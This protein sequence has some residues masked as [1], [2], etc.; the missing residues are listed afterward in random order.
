MY[1]I[2]SI[3]PGYEDIEKQ[4][5]LEYVDGHFKFMMDDVTKVLIDTGMSFNQV[6]QSVILLLKRDIFLKG[7]L[8]Q[9]RKIYTLNI[10]VLNEFDL[11]QRYSG[12]FLAQKK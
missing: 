5:K 9:W 6:P 2:G 11:V 12:R 8:D 3:L 7:R 4:P 10:A 1:T